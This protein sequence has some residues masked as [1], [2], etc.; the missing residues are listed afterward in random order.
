MEVG[1]E[2]EVEGKRGDVCF[3]EGERG[4]GDMKEGDLEV[5]AVD[6]VVCGRRRQ[7]SRS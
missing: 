2:A 1:F 7:K 4:V 6:C 3:G 5:E